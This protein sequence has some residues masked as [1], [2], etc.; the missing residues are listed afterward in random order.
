MSRSVLILPASPRNNSN[1]DRLAT[2]A[3]G[4]E[5][6]MDGAVRGL[7]G[8]AACLEKCH[9]SG[10]VRG[11]GCDEAGSIRNQPER[12]KTARDMGSTIGQLCEEGT[13]L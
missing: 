3:D 8:W 2:A 11:M 9:L 6:A 10:V 13:R 5:S 1:S 12:L 7:E 4:E